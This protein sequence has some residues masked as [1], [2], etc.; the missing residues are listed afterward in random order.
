MAERRKLSAA[1]CGPEEELRR[2]RSL[3]RSGG[4]TAEALCRLLRSGG[5][6]A[7]EPK[8]PAVR[9]KNCGGSLPP[10]ADR[11]KNCGGTEASIQEHRK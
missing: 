6:T 10:P 9:R 4:R 8:P 3:L 7:E 2:N 5:R 11:R 1:S